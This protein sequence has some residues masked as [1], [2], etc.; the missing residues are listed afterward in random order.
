LVEVSVLYQILNIKL[1]SFPV[2]ERKERKKEDTL[3]CTRVNRG[4]LTPVLT[5]T[6]ILPE[7]ISV[8]DMNYDPFGSFSYPQFLMSVPCVAFMSE[9]FCVLGVNTSGKAGS[10]KVRI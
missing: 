4:L 8:V 9:L 7:F 6:D 10:E 2:L 1:S 3:L 5:S